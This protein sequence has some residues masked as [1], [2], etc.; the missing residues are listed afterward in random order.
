MSSP[1]LHFISPPIPY[2]ID[3]GRAFYCV[4]E[5]HVS[6][7][8]IGVF[9]LVVVTK[10]TLCLGEGE[11]E[12]IIQE[13]ESFILRPDAS[14]FGTEAC[15]TN[16]EIIWIHFHTFGAWEE[17]M[18]MG[19]CLDNQSALFASHKQTAYLNHSEVC[20]VFLPKHMRL[21]PKAMDI[22]EQ[23]FQLEDEPRSLRNWKRQSVFQIFIQYLDR[24]LASTS[25]GT[26][27]NLAEKIE[28]FIRQNYSNK[29][30]NSILQSVLNYHPNYMARCMLKVYGMTPM[31]YLLQYRIEQA[32]KLL[33]QTEWSATRISEEVGFQH[34]S[35]FTFCFSN[36]EGISPLNFRRKM[37]GH[38]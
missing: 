21:K 18:S 4:G 22:L 37:R 26:A 27:F 36:K 1:I 12:W 6:R 34:G 9:D 28:L 31:D 14:H 25:D 35:Y 30:T 16:T 13:G 24:E 32:K 8:S 38:L 20:S 23:F 33:V 11:T 7:N 5:R 19:D 29:I 15:N 2:F 10:G 17:C 3:C